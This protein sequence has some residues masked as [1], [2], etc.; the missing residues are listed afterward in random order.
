MGYSPWDRKEADMAERLTLSLFNVLFGGD[1]GKPKTKVHGI[2]C[3]PLPRVTASQLSWGCSAWPRFPSRVHITSLWGTVSGE[4]QL[5]LSDQGPKLSP[6]MY[7]CVCVCVY[8]YIYIKKV[9][10]KVAHLC[11]T[12]CNPMDYIIHGIL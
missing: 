12:L 3:R 4:S 7:V 9:K 5:F 2:W 11:P 6:C 10:L 8:I 1:K